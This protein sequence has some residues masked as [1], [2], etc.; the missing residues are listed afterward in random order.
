MGVRATFQP[1]QGPWDSGDNSFDF[2]GPHFP[3]L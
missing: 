2:S 1:T 3:H